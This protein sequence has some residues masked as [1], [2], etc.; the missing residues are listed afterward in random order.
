[1]TAA[2]VTG[3]LVVAIAA[4]LAL[5]FGLLRLVSVVLGQGQSEPVFLG[6]TILPVGETLRTPLSEEAAGFTAVVRPT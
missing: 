2:R 6:S 4:V 3:R 5:S 1:M